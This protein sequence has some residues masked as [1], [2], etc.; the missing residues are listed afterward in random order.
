MAQQQTLQ[1]RIDAQIN[2]EGTLKSL[3][4]LKKLQRE[5]VAGSDDFKKIQQRIDDIGDATKTAKGQSQGFIDSLA[6][7]PGIVGQLGR[8]LDTM[9]SSTNKFGLALKATGIGL[10]VS[11]VGLLVNAFTQ[12]EKA[13][14]KLEPI[15]IA[16]EQ[17]LGG[18]F[19][20]LE[21][22]FDIL[23]D[24]AIQ[25]L[26]FVINQVGVFFSTLYGLFTFIKEAGVGVGKIL[27]G[28]FTQDLTMIN[29]G[30]EQ[31]KGSTSAA[32]DAIYAQRVHR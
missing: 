11:L 31:L 1:V 18:V 29:E 16:F 9:T 28:I 24:L 14:K 15:M 22:V 6:G 25:A 23:V 21:P 20:A 26:P 5:T 27:T 4:E 7:A 30:V 8:G 10:I 3:R 19:K 17:I 12:N 13:M 2:A 32:V